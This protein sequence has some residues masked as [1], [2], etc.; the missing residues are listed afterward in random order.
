VK[1]DDLPLDIKPGILQPQLDAVLYAAYQVGASDISI[2]T[3]DHIVFMVSG[4]QIKASRRTMQEGELASIVSV[5]YGTN[6]VAL[7]SQG[8]PLDGRYEIRPSR[9]EKVGFRVNILPSRVDG[10]DTAISITI[11]VLPKNPPRIETMLVP[12]EIVRNAMPRNGLVVIAGVTS[13][14]KS[15]LIAGLIRYA[16]EL[17][18]GNDITAAGRKIITYEAPIEYVYDGI[19]TPGTKISQT[20]IGGNGNGLK[21]WGEAVETAMRRA[22][23]I[24]LIGE[25]RDGHTIDGCISMA[26]TGH[27]T[28]TTVHAD[29]VGVAFRRMVA[30]AAAVGGGNDSVSER[31]LGSLSMIVVQTLCP[32]IGGGRIALREWIVITKSLQN[33]LFG[34]PASSIANELQQEV[35]RRGTS[36]G[37]SAKIAFEAGVITLFDACAFSG[38]TRPEL[39]ALEINP[40]RFAMFDGG[41]NATA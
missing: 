16:Y 25:C 23:S 11:R 34:M 20:E 30:M 22:S 27:C 26:L 21:T 28:M 3:N 32:K 7:I 6:G 4:V 33:Q 40:K 2:Q 14:G 17:E 29:R 10:N 24:V 36:M 9:G 41:E 1:I 12:D 38:L 13:S 37:H 5:L 15:T 18:R 35:I 8:Q 19:E 39:E 31:L